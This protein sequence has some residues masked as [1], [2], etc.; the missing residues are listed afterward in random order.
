M[1]PF[2]TNIH[3]FI[4]PLFS[5]FNCSMETINSKREYKGS[6]RHKLLAPAQDNTIPNMILHFKS[7]NSEQTKQREKLNSED[8]TEK[9]RA[10][11]GVPMAP[12]SQPAAFQGWQNYL[13]VTGRLVFQVGMGLVKDDKAGGT[14][15]FFTILQR[16]FITLLDGGLLTKWKLD[17]RRKNMEKQA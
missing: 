9:H 1:L 2:I 5:L 13:D 8:A 17:P 7:I 11:V 6:Q 3:T 12:T 4:H 15:F 10:N 16:V 14:T